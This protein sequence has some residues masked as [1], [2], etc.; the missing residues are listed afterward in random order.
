MPYSIW[1]LSFHL[2]PFDTLLCREYSLHSYFIII[3]SNL[4]NVVEKILSNSS[5]SLVQGLLNY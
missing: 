1:E 4:L 3:H 2:F 5:E